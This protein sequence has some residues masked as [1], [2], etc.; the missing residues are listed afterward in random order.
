MPTPASPRAEYLDRSYHPHRKHAPQ[1][2]ISDDN[3]HVTE[4]IG[5][6]YGSDDEDYNISRRN[7][8]PLSFITSPVESFDVGSSPNYFDTK[9]ASPPRTPLAKTLS[10]ERVPPSPLDDSSKLLGRNGSLGAENSPIS[11]PLPLSRKSSSS[12][13]AVQQFPLNDIDYESSPAAVAQEL[14][15]LQA[16]RRMSMNVDT[17]DP[18]LPTFSSGLSLPATA[19][20]HSDDEDDTSR[21]FWVPARLHPEL[22]PKEFKTFVEDRVDRIRQR[23]GSGDSLSPGTLERSGSD[24]LR[25]KKSMLSRQIDSSRGYKDG[26]DRLERKKSEGRPG[27]GHATVENL[28]EL[29]DLVNDP[30]NVIRSINLDTTRKSVDSGVEVPVTEDMPILPP[31]GSTL[32]RSTRT[33]YRRGSLRKGERM[34]F[35]KR[36]LG[37]HN[38]TDTDDSP[39]S[40]PTV[41]RPDEASETL[42]RIQTEPPPALA[43]PLEQPPRSTKPGIAVSLSSDNLIEHARNA[44]RS[45]E[46]SYATTENPRPQQ[47]HSRIATNGRT[48]APVPGVP[49]IVETPPQNDR[50]TNNTFTLP[51]R[52]SSHTPP[53]GSMRSGSPSGRSIAGSRG[54]PSRPPM[55]SQRASHGPTSTLEDISSHPSPLPGNGS[56]RTDALTMVPTFEDKKVE[57]KD[58]I[59]KTSWNW[60][61]GGEE[62]ER[63]KEK[64]RERQREKEEQKEKE[65]SKKS[66]SVSSRLAKGNDKTRLDVLQSS[67]DGNASTRGRESLV[68]DRES[69]KLE[70]ERKKESSR[71]SGDG[72]TG[73]K[74]K[75][76]G[77]LSAIFG[78]KKSKISDESSQKKRI[79]NTRALSP[80]PPPRV[81][82][83]DIDYNW[84]RFSIL[85]ERAIYRMAHIK[86]ANPKRAL[87]SQVLLSNFMYSYLAKVQMMHPQ[88]QMQIPAGQKSAQ[89]RSQNSARKEEKQ[90]EEYSQ[91]QRWQEQQAQLQAHGDATSGAEQIGEIGSLGNATA[92]HSATQNMYSGHQSQQQPRRS[93]ESKGSTS[94]HDYLGYATNEQPF[95]QKGLWDDTDGEKEDDLW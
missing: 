94:G 5:G 18:D 89:S 67:I 91:Y 15:N 81:L 10:N 78:G 68:L 58:G 54:S 31:L 7:S 48:T 16:I 12:E 66:K 73:K 2:S 77:L 38:D 95:E 30:S 93:L 39:A 80:E 53:P 72:S 70:E 26:A 51:E 63:E 35:S 59:R 33:T 40:S 55:V 29:E 65:A 87:H 92:E 34:P 74:E 41:T 79:S 28:S 9:R 82:K 56:T 52:K 46:D 32:K 24:G 64:D 62:K 42:T 86:L 13:T 17:A 8:R 83:P 45:R 25:R 3:H 6:M 27:H 19:P 76:S 90:A 44:P 75:D 71:K 23:S 20:S 61:M 43:Q 47:F 69:I 36:A 85:E 37:R 11:P 4:A 60:L 88:M 84:T 1:I 57:K 21:L 50:N 14:S 49:H 22:A